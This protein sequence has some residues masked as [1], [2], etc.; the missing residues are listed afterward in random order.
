MSNHLENTKRWA[1][2]AMYYPGIWITNVLTADESVTY[3][4]DEEVLKDG[5]WSVVKHTDVV[6]YP[7]LQAAIE[8]LAAGTYTE[9]DGT[10]KP[11]APY[12]LTA[13]VRILNNYEDADFDA[14]TDDIIAQ[15][16]VLGKQLF[17]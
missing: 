4:W 3:H 12:H 8:H 17:S 16:A 15:Q 13:C 5:K 10:E 11:L 1:E 2:D 14:F 6:D 9:Y 7:A